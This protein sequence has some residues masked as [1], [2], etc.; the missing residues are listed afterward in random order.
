MLT[1]FRINKIMG[2]SFRLYSEALMGDE[3]SEVS[4]PGMSQGAD[5]PDDSIY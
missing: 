1:I 5:E 3:D 2:E 4:T